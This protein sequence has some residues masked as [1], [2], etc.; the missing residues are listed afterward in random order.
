MAPDAGSERIKRQLDLDT[1][2]LYRAGRPWALMVDFRAE[3]S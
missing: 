2:R 3:R 1:V